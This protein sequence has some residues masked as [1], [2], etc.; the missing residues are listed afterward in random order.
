MA[1]SASSLCIAFA[2]ACA[3]CSESPASSTAYGGG[4]VSQGEDAGQEPE[5]SV[6][7][8]VDDPRTH[9]E[10]INACTDAEKI[11]KHPDLPLL[12]EDGGLPP[13]P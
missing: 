8:C 6:P 10:I 13:L 4:S 11:E 9:D 12:L 7:D 5:A 1:R 2:L 3:G